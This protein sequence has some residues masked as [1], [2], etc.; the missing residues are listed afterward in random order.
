[1]VPVEYAELGTELTVERP[2]ET[3]AAVVADR[4]F[5]KPEKAEQHLPTPGSSEGG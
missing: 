3:V 5:I 1:M 4:V 2:D